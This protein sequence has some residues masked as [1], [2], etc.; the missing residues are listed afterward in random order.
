MRNPVELT[1]SKTFLEG[2]T[3]DETKTSKELIIF[4][5]GK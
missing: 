5:F 3:P 1:R 2:T 4:S